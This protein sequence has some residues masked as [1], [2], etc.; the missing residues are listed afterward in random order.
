M[1]GSKSA[2]RLNNLV[3]NEALE[4]HEKQIVY[5]IALA[6]V[7]SADRPPKVRPMTKQE[8]DLIVKSKEKIRA[9]ELLKLLNQ[10]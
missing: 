9:P 6:R 4:P 10:T 8:F 1:S 7:L 2:R 5:R 3:A